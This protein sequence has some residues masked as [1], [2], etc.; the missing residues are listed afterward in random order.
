MTDWEKYFNTCD[1]KANLLNTCRVA[2]PTLTVPRYNRQRWLVAI[3]RMLILI[4]KTSA[5]LNCITYF[6]PVRSWSLMVHCA[7]TVTCHWC[8]CVLVQPLWSPVWSYLSKI[9][10]VH[11]LWP[12]SSKNLFCTWWTCHLASPYKEACPI[13]IAVVPIILKD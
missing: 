3:R 2:K 11:N 12:S 8:K 9:V 10:N 6:S 7:C 1:K 13:L 5:N 4:Q